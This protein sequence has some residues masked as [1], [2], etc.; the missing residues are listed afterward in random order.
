M[1]QYLYGKLIAQKEQRHILIINLL[2]LKKK[3]LICVSV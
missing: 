2:K 3:S 1:W